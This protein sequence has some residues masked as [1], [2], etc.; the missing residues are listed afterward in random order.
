M[1]SNWKK[2]ARVDRAPSRGRNHRRNMEED[3]SPSVDPHDAGLRVP[4]PVSHLYGP[5]SDCRRP[6]LSSA[7]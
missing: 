6:G 1:L 3:V 2:S 5:D 4:D 7:V